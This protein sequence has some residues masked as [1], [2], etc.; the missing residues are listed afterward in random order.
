MSNDL[1]V[2]NLYDF[3]DLQPHE[4]HAGCRIE[5]SLASR[6]CSSKSHAYFP[7]WRDEQSMTKHTIGQARNYN[8][9]YRVEDTSTTCTDSN[10]IGDLK[11]LEI[12]TDFCKIKKVF[13]SLIDSEESIPS[14]GIIIANQDFRCK[15]NDH[16]T[17]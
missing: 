6:F 2:E 10:C 11:F 17:K 14:Q 12:R 4:S 1:Q 5:K 9:V 7:G 13:I 3:C 8:Y 15:I 16:I